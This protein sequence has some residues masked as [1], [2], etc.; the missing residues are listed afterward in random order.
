MWKKSRPR[1]WSD[2]TCT[3]NIS[4]YS[5]NDDRGPRAAVVLNLECMSVGGGHQSVM[6]FDPPLFENQR[7]K[8]RPAVCGGMW[9]Q[10]LSLK[11]YNVAQWNLLS[12]SF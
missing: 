1:R 3:L 2:H 12:F 7:V 8:G 9:I 6:D 4:G 11:I 10:D 5:L